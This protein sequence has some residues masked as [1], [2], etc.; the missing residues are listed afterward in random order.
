MP[1]SL[2]ITF[3]PNFIKE[4]SLATEAMSSPPPSSV[5]RSFAG[6]W[7]HRLA[8][9]LA[10]Q[11]KDISVVKSSQYC[12]ALISPGFL[13]GSDNQFPLKN[14]PSLA[15]Q[16]SSPPLSS[17]PNPLVG[18]CRCSLSC[19]M[20]CSLRDVFNPPAPTAPHAHFRGK[21]RVIPGSLVNLGCSQRLALL[22]VSGY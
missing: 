16:T 2:S 10:N 9:L 22:E 8:D 7:S 15:P 17:H 14:F 6:C 13:A 1:V 12:S 19:S 18:L 20:N 21:C 5:Q 4:L 11:A 3:L